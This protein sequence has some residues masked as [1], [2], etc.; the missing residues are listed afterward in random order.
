MATP[1]GSS[2]AEVRAASRS[3]SEENKKQTSSPQL[4][5]GDADTVTLSKQLSPSAAPLLPC[6]TGELPTE[7]QSKK[8][9]GATFRWLLK[10]S[11]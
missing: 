4:G 9:Q 3:G 7:K 2:C 6:A 11:T 10:C 5:M 1:A 8:I